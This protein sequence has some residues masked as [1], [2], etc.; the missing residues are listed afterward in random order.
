MDDRKFGS[1]KELADAK[2]KWD[3]G[4]SALES[5]FTEE[6]QKQ[7]EEL[8]K[9]ETPPLET[10]GEVKK[11]YTLYRKKFHKGK[12][13]PL[14][15]LYIVIKLKVKNVPYEASRLIKGGKGEEVEETVGEYL[16]LL[17]GEKYGI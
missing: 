6:Q 16:R 3:K 2:A 7:L 12:M 5:K 10:D 13:A 11:D 14:G 8:F 17:L 9:E 1:E 15:S 4:E